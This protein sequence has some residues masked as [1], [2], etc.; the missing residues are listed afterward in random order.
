MNHEVV[1]IGAG[2]SGLCCARILH[3]QGIRCVILEASDGVGGRIRTDIVDGFRLDRG[4]QVFLTSYPEA[5]KVLD[6]PSLDL[7]PFLPGALVRFANTFYPMA[8]PW[9]R[10]LASLQS[11]SS[12]I[13]SLKDKLRVAR[14]RSKVLRGSFDKAFHIPETTTHQ[15]LQQEGFSNSM[16]DRFFRPFLGG[17]FLEPEL[18]TSSRMLHFLF[19]MFALGHACLPADGM[20]AIPRQLASILPTGT[21]RLNTVVN[22]IEA[23]QVRLASGETLP[24]KKIVVAT[25]GSSA[26]KLLKTTSSASGKGTTCLYFSAPKAPLKQPILMLNGEGRGPINNVCIPTQVA[27]SYGPSNKSLISVTVLGAHHSFD[28]L[29]NDVRTQLGEWFGECTQTWNH[30][31]TYCIPYALPDQAPPALSTPERSVRYSPGIYVCGDHRDN[32]SIHGAMV[33]GRRA[34]EAILSDPS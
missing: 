30:L 34:A 4:F 20:E 8:D 1:I 7:K 2:L 26:A 19:R 24:A 12:P 29:L 28:A 25:D 23:G 15:A 14:F 22:G 33:S 21:I 18:Q 32:A 17:I 9:R 5:Q 3:Q 27:P 10:P 11:L 31:K 6:Y 13:G 16:I